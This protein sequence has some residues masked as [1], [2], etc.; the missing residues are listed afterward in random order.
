MVVM[1]DNLITELL[2][3]LKVYQ[4][5]KQKFKKKFDSVPFAILKANNFETMKNIQ[6][7]MSESVFIEKAYL[8]GFKKGRRSYSGLNGRILDEFDQAVDYVNLLFC[9]DDII[10]QA[11]NTAVEK[12]HKIRTYYKYI[13]YLGD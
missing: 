7:N 4:A 10:H 9:F 12:K 11:I 3:N 2:K 6:E 8:L 5:L 13:N 1:P